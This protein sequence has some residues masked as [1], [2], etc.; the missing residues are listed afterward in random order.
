[1]DLDSE[2]SDGKQR[3]TYI[4]R[5]TRFFIKLQSPR[6]DVVTLMSRQLHAIFTNRV[7]WAV[8]NILEHWWASWYFFG[9]SR[10]STGEPTL[11]SCKLR[12]IF[13][14]FGNCLLDACDTDIAILALFQSWRIKLWIFWK[15]LDNYDIPVTVVHWYGSN[16]VNRM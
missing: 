10:R 5:F 8:Q 6:P 2:R 3:P 16:F 11:L 9:P 4:M 15:T 14:D 7:C 12:R 13:L 1:M